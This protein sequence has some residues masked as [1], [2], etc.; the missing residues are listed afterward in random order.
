M[1]PNSVKLTYKGKVTFDLV[2]SILS[3]ISGRLDSI[4]EDINT[5]K[6]V[7]TV[8]ME[9]LQNLCNYIE[10][11]DFE[12]TL[13]DSNC[14]LLSITN[15]M[16]EYSIYTGNFMLNKRVSSLKSWLD[17]INAS[18]G[19]ERKQLYN[20]ILT[21]NTFSSKGGGGLGF[22]DIA[23]KSNGNLIYAFQQVDDNCS[24]FS[25]EINIKRN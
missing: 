19:E 21:N 11:Q 18:D 20:K 6:K 1:L 14:A 12:T 5:R 15:G 17:Q 10:E 13:Y 2:D 16:D 9:C 3:I 24:F 23:R 25:L 4:E 22:L 7:Y 8:L